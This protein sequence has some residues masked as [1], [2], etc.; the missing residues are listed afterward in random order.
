[1]P[2][3][4]AVTDLPG[5]EPVSRGKV[6]DIYAVDDRLL[7][8]ATDR[9]SCFDVVL[10][11]AIP[12]KGKVLTHLTE[13]WLGR[14]A[15]LAPNHL[16][17]TDVGRM[18]LAVAPHAASLRGRSM[19]VRRAD[20]VPVECVVRGYLSGSGWR[21]YR[22]SGSVCGVALPDGL[23]ESDRLPEPIFT[24]TTKADAGHDL[25]LTMAEVESRVGADLAR[26]LKDLSIRVYLEASDYAAGQ[27]IIISDTKFEWGFV[28]GELTLADE[29]L[30]PDSSRFWPADL[31][32][33]G[34]AQASYDKQYVRDW[35]DEAGW[36]HEPPSPELPDEVVRR[37][38][39][40]YLEACRLL[41]GRTPE[42]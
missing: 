11:T 13:F 3:T 7:I 41:T 25:P 2:E 24:P 9:I 8:V 26:R 33:P 36:D 35:L 38:A 6:R 40:K 31:Y 15:H 34:R 22:E 37:T 28:D 18:G 1:M 29:V 19:L 10:R 27:G 14:L 21:S 12:W 32:A 4:L 20:I 16:V 42:A 23:R 17:T 5:L 30:T 39:E